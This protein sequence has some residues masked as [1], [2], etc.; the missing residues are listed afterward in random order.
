MPDL[1]KIQSPALSKNSKINLDNSDLA[2]CY[3]NGKRKF[4]VIKEGFVLLVDPDPMKLGWAVIKRTFSLARIEL[5]QLDTKSLLL[6]LKGGLEKKENTD[7]FV[8]DDHIRCSAVRARLLQENVKFFVGE[9]E[10]F[11]FHFL[12]FFCMR[13]RLITVRS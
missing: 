1:F 4:M 11:E 7:T 9:T 2:S 6:I 3:L 12:T 5:K 10:L 8:F 13:S